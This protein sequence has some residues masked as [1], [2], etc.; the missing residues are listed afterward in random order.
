MSN[1][2]PEGVFV[3]LGIQHEMCTRYIITSHQPRCTIF[4]PNYLIN[5][6]NLEK[7]KKLLHM[8]Y[9]FRVSIQILSHIFFILRRIERD[10]MENLYWSSCE[11]PVT[12]LRF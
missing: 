1:T 11:V 3:A 2:Q 6:T 4:F 5:D 8:K 7:K 12:L 10:M 9:V